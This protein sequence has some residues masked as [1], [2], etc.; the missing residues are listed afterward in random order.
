MWLEHEYKKGSNQIASALFHCLTN[1][2]LT[3][4][5]SLKIVADGCGGQNKNKIVIGMPVSYTHLMLL[6][7]SFI[8]TT[9]NLRLNSI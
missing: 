9:V 3:N 6:K 7:H 2:D 5:N 1:S 4:V 8:I